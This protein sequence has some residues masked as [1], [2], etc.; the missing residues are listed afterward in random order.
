MECEPLG[1]AVYFAGLSE[2]R[3]VVVWYKIWIL[4]AA[5]EEKCQ[6]VYS[7]VAWQEQVPAW[8][9]QGTSYTPQ[10]EEEEKAVMSS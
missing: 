8:G 1:A 10:V 5:E 4:K 7:Q 6:R 3:V 9:W 2:K